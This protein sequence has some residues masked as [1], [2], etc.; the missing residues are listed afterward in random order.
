MNV[1]NL[2]L[3]LDDVGNKHKRKILYFQF[4][5]DKPIEA[6][7]G[8]VGSFII[9]VPTKNNGEVKFTDGKRNFKLFARVID[10]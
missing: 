4:G 1:D 5:D 8:N 7:I 2:A 9:E 10:D 3:S 6:A